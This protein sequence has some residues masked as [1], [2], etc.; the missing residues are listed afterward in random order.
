MLT[1]S[2]NVDYGS[3]RPS[4]S[5]PVT[6]APSTVPSTAASSDRRARR[7]QSQ[8]DRVR[9]HWGRLAVASGAAHVSRLPLPSRNSAWT[10]RPNNHPRPASMASSISDQAPALGSCMLA[11]PRALQV[12]STITIGAYT[13]FAGGPVPARAQL[14]AS[15]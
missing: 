6:A 14:Q 12:L 10:P 4:A 13:P 5:T 11:L 15:T 1:L 7:S 8:C 9:W 2:T 3:E